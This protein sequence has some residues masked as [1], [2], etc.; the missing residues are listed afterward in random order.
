[1]RALRNQVL[2]FSSQLQNKTNE[3]I[4]HTGPKNILFLIKQETW[5]L[6]NNKSCS[7]VAY[8]IFQYRSIKIK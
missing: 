2:N 3:N 8:R 4:Q 5:F 7:R 6:I 1:M